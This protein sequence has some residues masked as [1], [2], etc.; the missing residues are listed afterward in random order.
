MSDRYDLDVAAAVLDDARHTITG[1]GKRIANTEA[2]L[3][4]STA[5][6]IVREWEE[7]KH[8]AARKPS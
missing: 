5:A 8:N 2:V 6:R 1:S 4:G 7:R 3:F